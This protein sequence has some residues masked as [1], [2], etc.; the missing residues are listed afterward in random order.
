MQSAAAVSGEPT[1]ATIEYVF[2]GPH[3]IQEALVLGPE[4]FKDRGL[5]AA[6]DQEKGLA[7]WR[8][9]EQLYSVDLLVAK[10]AGKIVGGIGLA[11][12][13]DQWSDY[14]YGAE[15]FFFVLPIERRGAIG[16]GLL[17][18]AEQW[19]RDRGVP[20]F[21]VGAFH[22]ADYDILSAWYARKG[23]RPF[24]MHFRKEL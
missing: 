3:E 7:H 10:R 23:Y 13:T 19:A 14:R 5:P 17:E 18:R 8:A 11:I 4:F 24:T 21:R 16:A 2:L 22:G 6:Y 15:L 9:C 20:E 12:S 1:S